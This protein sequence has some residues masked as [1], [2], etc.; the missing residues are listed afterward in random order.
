M[1]NASDTSIGRPGL[2][3]PRNRS[4]NNTKYLSGSVR[5]CDVRV[6]SGWSA[7]NRL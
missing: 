3:K 6:R 4:E 2:R 5:K 7:K 1:R